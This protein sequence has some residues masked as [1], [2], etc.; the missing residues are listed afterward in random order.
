MAI[1]AASALALPA[2]ASG[3]QLLTDPLLRHGEVLTFAVH[4]S[5]FGGMGTATMRVDGDTLNGRSVS[6]MS[7]DF[8]GHVA[9]FN[10]SDHTR[11]WIDPVSMT[12]MRYTKVERS[13]VSKRDEAV[14]IDRANNVWRDAR[15]AHPLASG[16][17]LDE[18]AFI[19][20]MRSVASN[21]AA[22]PGS[23]EIPRHFDAARNPV[24][25][26]V[27]PSVDLQSMGTTL[28]ARVLEIVV[29]DSRQKNGTSKITFYI[30]VDDGYLPLRIDSSMPLGGTMSLTLKSVTV[31]STLARNQ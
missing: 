4:S 25:V 11:S 26:N 27:L 8:K 21:G 7:F 17:P 6:R 31:P 15:G 12:T 1:L 2:V 22:L 14:D 5:R 24:H 16:Q 18:L 9:V 3:Q 23:L 29:R 10:V 19:Y 20:A 13:P 28:R 30:G